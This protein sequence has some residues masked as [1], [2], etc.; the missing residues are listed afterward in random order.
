MEEGIPSRTA[1]R[2]ALRRAAHQLLDTP[3][4]FEDPLALR[5]IRPETAERLRAD[6]SDIDRG[7]LSKYLRPFLAARSRIAEDTIAGA[8]GRGCRQVVILG[9]GLDTYAFRQ[10]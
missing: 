1:S 4:V 3:L 5:I 8:F 2:V 10:P 9:A 6:P 7:K